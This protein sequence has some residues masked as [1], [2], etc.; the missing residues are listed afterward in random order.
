MRAKRIILAGALLTLLASFL[1]AGA[2]A[3]PL[4]SVC[5]A[6]DVGG[7]GDHSFNDAVSAGLIA[8][9]KRYQISLESTV[10]IGSAEDRELRIRTFA[11]KSCDLTIVVGSAYAESVK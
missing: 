1:P 9:A 5:V 3:T 10:T 11:K 6:Y 2:Q 7:P 4:L 8:A